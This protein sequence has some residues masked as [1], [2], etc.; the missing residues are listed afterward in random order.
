[1]GFGI[2]NPRIFS[3]VEEGGPR[4]EQRH[5]RSNH[6]QKPIKMTIKT[7]PRGAA[8][9]LATVTR[10]SP[11]IY[12]LSMHNTSNGLMDNRLT[13][14]F[15]TDSLLP[16]LDEIEHDFWKDWHAGNKEAALVI[17]GE[18]EKHK[19]FSSV[20]RSHTSPSSSVPKRTCSVADNSVT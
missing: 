16:A 19:F 3:A 4:K 15:I 11:K 20:S 7:Y 9:A 17:T 14:A 1:M 6:Q 12:L 2:S 18:R 10:P 8:V 13:P 5:L